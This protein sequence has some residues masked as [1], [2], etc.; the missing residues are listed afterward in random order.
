MPTVI[1]FDFGNCYSFPSFVDGMNE[2]TRTGGTE[3]DL[4]PVQYGRAQE[5][6]PSRFF[7]EEGMAEPMVG[8]KVEQMR[9]PRS[10]YQVLL[11]RHLR[12]SFEMGGR[13]FTYREAARMV[14]EDCIRKANRRLE[15]ISQQTTNLISLAYPA[16]YLASDR[17][18]L[19]ET[20]EEATLEDGTHL[21]VVGTIR[22]PAA[23]ALEYLAGEMPER[24]EPMTALVYDLGGG[25]FDATILTCYPRGIENAAGKVRYYDEHVSNGLKGVGGEDFTRDIEAILRE[26][27]QGVH[28]SEWHDQLFLEYFSEETESAK[29][30]LSDETSYVPRIAMHRCNPI[31]REQFEERAHD[32]LMQTIDLTM[33]MLE[34]NPA[35]RP[36]KIVLT[37]G[38]SRMPMVRK[39]MLAALTKRKLGYRDEDIVLYQ[40]SRAISYGAARYGAP[41][42]GWGHIIQRTRR[43]LGIK[44]VDAR[45]GRDYVGVHIPAGTEIPFVPER[46][47]KSATSRPN[48]RVSRFSVYEAT[49]DQPD[50][51]AIGRDWKHIGDIRLDHGGPVPQG[52]QC[53]ER[54]VIDESGS[55]CVEARRPTDPTRSI[56]RSRLE[57]EFDGEDE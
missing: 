17:Q 41:E 31:T 14:V 37:G 44:Y 48:M 13:T 25:T 12:E 51:L 57:W 54:L 5:G 46:F 20:V 9:I 39:A 24:T 3:Y 52:T 45:T 32:K 10:R 40:P 26:S 11:K 29:H 21:E 42:S 49:V 18:L 55:L 30:I 33:Q 38:A 1:G 28:E 47:S 50:Q 43:D 53:E 2:D 4:I 35:G 7:Y 19:V 34:E 22:E 36:E 23:A 15:E 27:V 8:L 56:T 16:D 6:I